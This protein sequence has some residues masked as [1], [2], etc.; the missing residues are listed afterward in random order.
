M[1]AR[2]THNGI[3][4]NVVHSLDGIGGL[5]GLTVNSGQNFGIRNW[6]TVH[7]SYG[8]TA[9]ESQGLYNCLRQATVAM[10][11]ENLL[12]SFRNQLQS[13]LPSTSSLPEVPPLGDMDITQVLQSKYYFS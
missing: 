10:F 4:A 2:K 5:L 7:D 8:T 9:G 11:S 3:A 13:M 1:D 12:E 6:M